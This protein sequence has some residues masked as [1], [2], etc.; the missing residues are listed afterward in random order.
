[1]KKI[2]TFIVLAFVPFL[3]MC[4]GPYGPMMGGWNRTGYNGCPFVFG[5]GYGG[6]IMGLLFLILVGIAI[7]FIVQNIRSKN[8]IGQANETPLEILKKRYAKGEITKEDFDRMK[9]ELQ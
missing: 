4:T 3:T 6:M 9:N 7:Y 5:Y 2:Q 1:M 8:E